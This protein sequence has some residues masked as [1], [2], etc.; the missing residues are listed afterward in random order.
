MLLTKTDSI[1]LDQNWMQ[2]LALRHIAQFDGSDLGWLE[3]S[4]NNQ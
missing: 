4:I 1:I 2:P 3:R